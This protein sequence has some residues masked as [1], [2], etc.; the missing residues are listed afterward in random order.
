MQVTSSGISIGELTALVSIALGIT[1]TL[2]TFLWRIFKELK[3]IRVEE[4]SKRGRIYERLDEVKGEVDRD[5]TKKEVCTVVHQGVSSDMKLIRDDFK[6]VKLKVDCIPAIKAG[7]D[8]LLK[9]NG[10]RKGRK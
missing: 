7:I 6:D 5:Y 4:E 1:G 8:M 2:G 3:S 10:S 9:N